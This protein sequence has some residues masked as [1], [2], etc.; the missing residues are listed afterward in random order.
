[1]EEFKINIYEWRNKECDAY[2][3]KYFQAG[4]IQI[5]QDVKEKEIVLTKNIFKIGI[6]EDKQ[7]M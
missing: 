1:M 4:T 3:Y 7:Q 6:H 2:F 5:L